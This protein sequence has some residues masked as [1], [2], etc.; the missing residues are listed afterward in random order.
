M[1]T[2]ATRRRTSAPPWHHAAVVAGALLAGGALPLAAAEGFSGGEPP[3]LT[4]GEVALRVV[5]CAA[6]LCGAA[7]CSGLTLGVMGLDTN[8]LLVLKDSGKPRERQW[9]AKIL[10]VRADGNLLLCTLLWLNMAVNSLLSIVIAD[11]TT[12]LAGFLISTPLLVI[13]GE[14]IPQAACQRHGMRLGALFVPVVRIMIFIAY[15]LA[16]PLAWALDKALGKEIGTLYS[17]EE[18]QSLLAQHTAANLLQPTEAAIMSGALQFATKLVR[19]VATPAGRMFAL[20]SSDVLDYAT[21]A[22]IYRTGYSRVPVW[23]P[24]QTS[25]VGL[26]YAKDLILVQPAARIP[27]AAVVHFFHR[28]VVNVVDDEDSLEGVLRTFSSSRQHFAVVRTVDASGPGDP[29]YR[30]AGV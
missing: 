10:T 7:L 15:P 19:D 23:N 4:P 6:L 30:I 3:E 16:K 8:T 29:V 27:V 17:K 13:L 11:I 26:L 28:E 1:A 20:R 25:I 9:A 2:P 21:M 5:G 14:I 22:A 24:P 12:G 18:F